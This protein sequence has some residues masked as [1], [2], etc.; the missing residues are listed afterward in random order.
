MQVRQSSFSGD[1]PPCPIDS[2]HPVHHH[3]DYERY[4]NCNDH[5]REEILR[6]LC[7]PCGHTISV[8]PDHRL[9]YRLISV[10]QLQQDFDA[11]AND[12]APPP[13]TETE[14]G[15]L[16]RAWRSF[17]GRVTVLTAVLG[18][19]IRIVKPNAASLWKQLR[20]QGNLQAILLR[21]ARPFNTSLLK[22]YKCL[23]PWP[24]PSGR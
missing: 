2:R 7:V 18:Q 3:G 14:K 9:P 15:C 22:D 24:P 21:L 20:R 16:V 6:F 4:A 1:Y 8:L 12:T 11:R 23:Q 17:I 10:P 5:Q 19:I 13:A